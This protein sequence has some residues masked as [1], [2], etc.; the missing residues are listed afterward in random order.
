MDAQDKT[1]FDKL[2][3]SVCAKNKITREQL[4]YKKKTL[5]LI[6][7][8]FEVWGRAHLDHSISINALSNFCGYTRSTIRNGIQRWFDKED[9]SDAQV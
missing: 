6:A 5:F 1:K 9:Q 4:W 2:V 8:R 3:A 7:V